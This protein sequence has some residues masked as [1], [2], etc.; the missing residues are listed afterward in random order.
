MQSIESTVSIFKVNP[1]F[2]SKPVKLLKKCVGIELVGFELDV[3]WKC[4]CDLHCVR[5][6]HRLARI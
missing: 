6:V 4:N 2:S 5:I 3:V 1:V